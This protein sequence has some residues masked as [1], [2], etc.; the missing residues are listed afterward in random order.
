[1]EGIVDG[2]VVVDVGV[3]VLSRFG[4]FIGGMVCRE[5]AI[6]GDFWRFGGS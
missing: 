1:M 4:V 2:V 3:E 6:L 5:V